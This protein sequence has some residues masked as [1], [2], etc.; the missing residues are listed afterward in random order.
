MRKLFL[1]AALLAVGTLHSITPARA[2]TWT[3]DPAHS[4]VGFKV[5]H[6]F[7][8]VVGQFQTF[9]GTI[10]FDPKNVAASSVKVAIDPASITTRNDYRDKDLRSDHFF[11]V[12][13]FP[14]MTYEST[15]VT[16]TGQ[17][18]FT[19]EGNLTMHGVT[20]TVPLTVTLLGVGDGPRGKVAGFEA[21]AKIDRKEFG[22]V[23]NRALDNGGTLV[24]DDVEIEIAIE[25]GSATEKEAEGKE[26]APKKS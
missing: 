14:T 6:I 12:E 11:D 3:I 26:P 7:T 15:K 8:K 22:I 1:A 23:W 5:R 25:A 19:V 18:A 24:G 9:S 16:A 10:E 2:E 17:N 21:T 13:K 20:K 4:A